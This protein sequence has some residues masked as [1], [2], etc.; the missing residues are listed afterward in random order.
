[1]SK[2]EV[3]HLSVP[4]LEEEKDRLWRRQFAPTI[5]TR[6]II[7]DISFGAVGP[8]LCFVFDPIA[9]R[10]GFMGPPLFSDYQAFTYLFS[11]AQ[12]GVL[13]MWLILRPRND[14]ANSMIGGVLIAGAFFCMTVACILAPFSVLGLIV[15]IG[16]IGF[17]PFITTFVYV[18]NGVR[19]FRSCA[20]QPRSITVGVLTLGLIL[21]FSLPL[22]LSLEIRAAVTDAV[23]EVCHGD[24][25]RADFAAHR[26][27]PLRFFAE[28]ELDQIVDAYSTEP[29]Q[30]RREH[31]KSLY[32][33]IT[34]DDIEARA[35]RLRD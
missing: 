21:A 8:I 19:A 11:T 25:Q 31:L 16:I 4:P 33:K 34:G 18:R 14:V 15:G 32:R 29:S 35:R 7:F 22:L 3:R 23:S 9:L 20:T 10:G 26:L 24:P 27:I 1:M 6:Q 12:I 17:T 2:M 28:A 13:S 5:T 30:E